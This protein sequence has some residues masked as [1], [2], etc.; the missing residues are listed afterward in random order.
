MPSRSPFNHA[1]G[2]GLLNDS[3][4]LWLGGFAYNI[5]KCSALVAELRAVLVGLELAWTKGYG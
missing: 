1:G 5:G 4:G 2:A 3:D